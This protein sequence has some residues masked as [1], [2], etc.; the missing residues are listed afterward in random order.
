MVNEERLNNNLDLTVVIPIMNEVESIALL[1][2]SIKDVLLKIDLKHYEIIVIDDGSTD[3][4]TE[5]L[6]RLVVEDSCVIAHRFSR[7]MGKSAALSLGFQHCHGEFV[8]TMDGDLQDDPIEIPRFLDELKEADLV[9]GWKQKRLDPL[10]KRLPSKFFNM[11]SNF[12]TGIKLKDINSGFKGYRRWCIQ[13]LALSGNLYRFLPAFVYQKGGIIKEIPVNHKKREF[14]KSKFGIKR[15]FNG[16]A[17]LFTIL[18]IT[19]FIF[20]PLYF[21]SLIAV[22]LILVGTIL[23]G[24]LSFEHFYKY[25]FLGNSEYMLQSRPLLLLGFFFFG[26]GL[27]VFLNGIM[28][29]FILKLSR[30]TNLSP[31]S[32]VLESERK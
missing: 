18:F 27:M 15:Y 17:D 7:N 3:G 22:P 11:M 28:A 8:I 23:I 29:E 31:H 26:T 30:V 10:E 2:K 6:K 19:R 25:V 32:R 4:T 24:F 9:T 14:G 21:F 20:K 12:A 5:V 13:D 1:V 16:F